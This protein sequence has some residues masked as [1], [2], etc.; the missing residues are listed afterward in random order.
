MLAVD[1]TLLV[2]HRITY[3]EELF[4]EVIVWVVPQP[5]A[6]CTH[7][8]KYRLA[9]VAQ[10][11]CVL[12]YDNEAGKGDHRHAGGSEGR[13]RF[14]TLDKLFADFERDIRR[15]LDEDHHP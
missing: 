6:G 15:F 10:G 11:E 1:A 7:T 14:S 12:R 4:A 13:Y 8:Y 3:A 9:F 2:R 5:V